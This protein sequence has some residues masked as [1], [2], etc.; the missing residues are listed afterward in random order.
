MVTGHPGGYQRGRKPVL[1]FGRVLHNEKSV[2][3]TDCA[4]VGGDSGGPLFDMQGK[5]IGINSRI[6]G[7]LTS[8]MHVPVNTYRDDW[9]RMIAGEAWGSTAGERPF[10]G[11]QGDTES[12]KALIAAVYPDTPA[13]K[14]GIKPGDIITQ[15]DGQPIKDFAELRALVGEKKP[16]DEVEIQVLRDDKMVT[17]KLVVGKLGG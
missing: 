7:A 8:N 2:V 10:I 1:R 6:G 11:V 14:A 12:E 16:G 9:D 17:F 4:L 3:V 13:E 5:V 15:F